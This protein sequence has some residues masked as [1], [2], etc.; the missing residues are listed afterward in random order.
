MR[1]SSI[2]VSLCL[3]FALT[4][5]S[6]SQSLTHPV[7]D[8]V[9]VNDNSLGN[10]T[11]KAFVITNNGTGGGGNFKLL[12]TAS[13][14]NALQAIHFGTTGISNALYG[15]HN[16]TGRGGWI[17]A[18]DSTNPYE[19]LRVSTQGL[20]PALY[21]KQS[22]SRWAA[23]FESL[24]GP[25]IR[26]TADSDSLA[27][28]VES[29]GVQ[30]GTS[31]LPSE[32]DLSVDGKAIF[33]EVKVDVST[34]WADYVFDDDYSLMPLEE[35]EH[36]IKENQHL[37]NIPSALDV[38]KAGGV[39]LGTMQIKLLEKIEELTLHVIEQQKAIE[40]TREENTLLRS[41]ITTLE[42]QLQK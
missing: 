14:Q 13:T 2:F 33:E 28:K 16:G 23:R 29:G 22:N 21:A 9:T 41:R 34:D 6:F 39:E 3:C 18:V 8:T 40:A 20:G 17:R 24:T 36:F 38:Q 4:Q 31:A 37:P 7:H 1:I 25:G 30:I 35:V 27:L 11:N 12:N 42:A 19:A 32:F 5:I 15:K 26:I 10:E